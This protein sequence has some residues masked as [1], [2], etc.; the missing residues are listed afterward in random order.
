MIKLLKK[1]FTT[2]NF[3]SL[4]GNAG[5]AALGF[6]SFGILT[7]QL[8]KEGFGNWMIFLAIATLAELLRT[9]LLQTSLIKFYSGRNDKEK[10]V[11]LGSGWVFA[12]ITTG[13]MA[14]ITLSVY[15]LGKPYLTNDGVRLFFRWYWV[16][17]LVSLPFNFSSWY[18]QAEMNFR[19]LLYIRLVNL[20][21]FISLLLYNFYLQQGLEYIV[22]FYLSA[23]LCTSVFSLVTGTT[24]I[25]SLFYASYAEIKKLF[26]FGKFSMG[27]MIG[28]NLLRNSDTLI[29]GAMLN[30]QAVALYSVPLKL[31][32]IIEIPLRSFV[33]TSLP[34]LSALLNTGDS[35]GFVRLFERSSG[36]YT[37]LIIPVAILCIVFAEPMVILL[38][39]AGYAE[40]AGILRIFAVFALLM[41]I[42]RYTGVSLDIL[43]KPSLNFLKVSVMLFLNV[44]GDFAV[45][46]WFGSLQGVAAVSILTFSSGVLFGLLFLK[47]L[48]DFSLK[49]IVI[50]GVSG[51]KYYISKFKESIKPAA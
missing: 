47:K 5:A 3:Y 16:M 51:S 1:L 18:L 11:V 9:G 34:S 29:I 48:L 28:A 32:E 46:Y 8:S 40:A 20:V 12:L 37:I 30:P 31:F 38:G 49:G 45:L 19:K 42:D 14:L 39:G 7:R 2:N 6:L 21:V 22:F 10:R 4:A 24:A 50:S 33:A 36:L 27:T 41:P 13:A 35:K 26:N 23:Q 44:L 15:Y 43:N 25:S 17:T